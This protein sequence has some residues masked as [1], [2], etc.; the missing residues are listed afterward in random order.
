MTATSTQ[1]LYLES[2][3]GRVIPDVE[4]D[5][6]SGIP[7]T[8]MAPAQFVI[9]TYAGG[10]GI[11][12]GDETPFLDAG[13]HRGFRD[14]SLDLEAC[15]FTLVGISSQSRHQQRRTAN[16]HRVTHELLSD[17][18]CRLADELGLPTTPRGPGR[19]YKRLTL[20]VRN[21]RITLALEPRPTPEQHPAYLVRWLRGQRHWLVQTRASR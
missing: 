2:L 6:T 19:A 5:S 18:S 3:R 7:F 1:L 17:P 21:R 15:G 16:V 13:L 4:L 9:Y 11:T 14:H 10:P 12:R 8:L 20:V